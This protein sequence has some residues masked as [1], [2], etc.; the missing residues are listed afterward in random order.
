V[1][2]RDGTVFQ[3][4]D[5]NDTAW[6]AGACNPASAGIEHAAMTATPIQQLL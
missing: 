3:L 4:L 1:I 6:H 5:L 2:D